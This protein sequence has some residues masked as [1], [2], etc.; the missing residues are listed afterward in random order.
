TNNTNIR[1]AQVQDSLQLA[2]VMYT[3]GS[4]GVPKGIAITQENIIE[5]AQDKFFQDGSQDRVLLHSS[6]SFDASTYELWIPL[7]SGTQIVI[8]PPM[9][10]DIFQFENIV[11]KNN[12]SSMLLP[13]GLFNLIAN[14]RP[15]CLAHVKHIMTG[16]DIASPLSMQ[17]VLNVCQNCCVTNCYGPTEA[18]M[19]V[20]AYS[21]TLDSKSN[22]PVPIGT[23]LD[24]TKIYVLDGYL[25]PVPAGVGGEL[26]ISGSGL[27]R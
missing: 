2:Y 5:L 1:L 17:R 3:S 13:T 26:Y 12:V 18:T 9:M 27:A 19:L 11:R 20:T 10:F 24:N 14:D 15:A 8:A 23:P 6:Y 22:A 4:T 7:L 16:G 21:V 25:R